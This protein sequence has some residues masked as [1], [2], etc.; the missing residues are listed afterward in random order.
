M[1][2]IHKIV[3]SLVIGL[4]GV[5]IAA[6]QTFNGVPR[7][8]I[9]GIGSILIN[10]TN[11]TV[12]GSC[13]VS[14]AA[15]TASTGINITSA[16]VTNTGNT[17]INVLWDA[18]HPLK[19][20]GTTDNSAAIAA[21]VA[22]HGNNAAYYFPCGDYNM[23]AGAEFDA[24][25]STL[26]NIKFYAA[27]PGCV[28]FNAT[29]GDVNWWRVTT[30]GNNAEG[31][32]IDGICFNSTGAAGAVHSGL[33]ITNYIKFKII[34]PCFNHETGAYDSTGTLTS[35]TG[36]AV[37]GS[38]TNFVSAM[39]GGKINIGGNLQTILSVTDATHLTLASNWQYGAVSTGT[40]YTASWNG[41]GILLEGVSSGG[42]TQYGE[43]DDPISFDVRV[44][45][46]TLP[47]TSSSQ[48][49]SRV[50]IDG[51]FLHC[52][53][54]V[55]SYASD[56]TRFTDTM[57]ANFKANN[58]MTFVGIESSHANKITGWFENTGTFAPNSQCNGG[59][60]T[61]NCTY[62]VRI[63][64]DALNMAQH[65]TILGAYM[66][67]AGTGISIDSDFVQFTQDAFNTFSSI[68]TIH[69]FATSTG[70][71]KTSAN[72]DD[73]DMFQNPNGFSGTKTAGSCVMTYTGGIVTSI[74]GC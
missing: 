72:I 4:A 50:N 16:V 67:F 2:K 55:D 3:L 66:T 26:E 7:Q 11:C 68:N 13:T 28:N 20:D 1:N 39:A 49:T 36:T 60:Q 37:A 44:G 29:S 35:V 10:G 57:Q 18:A 14:T 33:R 70:V 5:G 63:N 21:L 42:D 17:D 52:N 53:R 41:W 6:Q 19:N 22:A 30:S 62:I 23:G 74:T 47:S 43:I 34:H 65:N 69:A 54:N 58:C 12:G 38:G 51:G 71:G 24:T 64:S 56:F 31:P 45:I 40:A 27:A 9:T 73:S 59:V 25:S 48:G 8:L 32:T 46:G 15:L 61:Q